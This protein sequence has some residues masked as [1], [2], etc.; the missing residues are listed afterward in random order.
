MRV[1]G[2]AMFGIHHLL[3]HEHFQKGHEGPVQ[4]RFRQVWL[5]VFAIAVHNFPE[6]LSIG[7]GAASG[8]AQIGLSVTLAIGLQNLPEGLA[9]AMALAGLGYSRLQA[10][11][12]AYRQRT[13]GSIV[14]FR[15]DID[16]PAQERSPSPALRL[17]PP[18]RVLAGQA[19]PVDPPRLRA[20]ARAG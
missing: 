10:L 3:P 9:V 20:A 8:D 17:P 14:V 15:R 13:D 19:G 5:F 4:S 12:V 18:R 7:V 16:A 1:G 11:G 2:L 6:G